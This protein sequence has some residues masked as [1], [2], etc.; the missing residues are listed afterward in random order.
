MSLYNTLRELCLCPSVSGREGMIREKLVKMIAP[1]C[2]EYYVDALGNLI[3]HKKGNGERVMLAAHMDEI[4]KQQINAVAERARADAA[5]ARQVNQERPLENGSSS[6]SVSV[7]SDPYAL[8]KSMN[9][10][11]RKAFIQNY[12]G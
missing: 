3:A 6:A 2:D 12:H 4:E 9:A 11:Q 1:L 7:G 10:Q 5:K 8:M